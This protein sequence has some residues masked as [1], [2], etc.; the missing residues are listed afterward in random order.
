MFEFEALQ[1]SNTLKKFFRIYKLVEEFK[2]NE[3]NYSKLKTLQEQIGSEH[4]KNKYIGIF[5]TY[6]P[7]L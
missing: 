5:K 1:K 4:F 3:K 2:T 6:F 7:E